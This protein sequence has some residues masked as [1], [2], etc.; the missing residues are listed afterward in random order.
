MSGFGQLVQGIIW[1]FGFVK[2]VGVG[3]ISWVFYY[4]DDESCNVYGNDDGL[5]YY[6]E[7]DC[8]NI[9]GGDQVVSCCLIFIDEEQLG[10]Q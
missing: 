7:V 5:V 8:V 10:K 4:Y 3:D 2:W 6:D 1:C 9:D